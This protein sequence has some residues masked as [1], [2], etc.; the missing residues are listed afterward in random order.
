MVMGDTGL[1]ERLQPDAL[2]DSPG[3]RGAWA[4]RKSRSSGRKRAVGGN[5][6]LPNFKRAE[7][8]VAARNLVGSAPQAGVVVETAAG[9]WRA[10]RLQVHLS[11]RADP[12][13][14]APSWHGAPPGREQPSSPRCLGARR[15]CRQTAEDPGPRKR[16][17]NVPVARKSLSAT[18]K[19]SK[20]RGFRVWRFCPLT[21]L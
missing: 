15:G 18:R 2:S 7:S 5:S 12:S 21:L 13:P 14:G 1:T 19:R 9:P 8:G 3:C 10:G 6:D 16:R 20:T 4:L 17:E 11:W